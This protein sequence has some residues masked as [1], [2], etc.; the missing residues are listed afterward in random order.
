MFEFAFLPSFCSIT[1]A[2]E[3]FV[4]LFE[5]FEAFSFT[6]LGIYGVILC[7][8]ALIYAFSADLASV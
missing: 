1:R 3:L 8:L 6:S 5:L 7:F 4:F 2:F